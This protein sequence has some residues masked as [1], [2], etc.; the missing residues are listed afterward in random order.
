M[1]A[2]R[3]FASIRLLGLLSITGLV[4]M[5]LSV[6]GGRVVHPDRKI[7]H[8]REKITFLILKSPAII[9]QERLSLI[10]YNICQNSSK[11]FSFFF[12]G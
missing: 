9:I 7:K 11:S 2:L 10:Y 1:G 3:K 12:I 4:V 5:G 6:F 8:K